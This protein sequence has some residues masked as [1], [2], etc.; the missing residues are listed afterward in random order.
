[1]I[2]GDDR[3][4]GQSTAVSVVIPSYNRA[5]LVKRAIDSVLNQTYREFEVIVVD[6][7]STDGTA[8]IVK[9]LADQ[10]VRYVKHQANRGVSES[11]N[12]GIKAAKGHLI[13]FLD[14]DDEWLP[15]KLRKQIDRFNELPSD[16]G[17]V[18]GA[19]LMVDE[20][21]GKPIR[22]V[23]PKNRGDV[24][25]DM[26]L[27]DFVVSPTPLVKKECFEKA[28]F[29]DGD[30]STSE[31]WDMWL[32]IAQHYKFDF[33]R[34][35]VARYYTS[36]DQVTKDVSKVVQGYLKFLTKH[37]A[38]IAGNPSILAYHFKTIAE[39][40]LVH[41]EYHL[42]NAYYARAIRTD[43]RNLPLYLHLVAARVAPRLYVHLGRWL[44]IQTE[45][46]RHRWFR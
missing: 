13:G 37:E 9:G 19:C 32:R 12:T 6:D 8:E 2:K 31:D 3:A 43:P 15:H 24:S 35:V 11:R 29:F 4:L 21:T 23:T 27:R 7:A 26:L 34:D 18:Y 30:F 25:R 40:Y 42:A 46:L 44:N 17:V 28:G 16:T 45:H 38:L 14:S 20:E 33:V 36:P 41:H 5:H 22:V 1:M 39:L 10:R